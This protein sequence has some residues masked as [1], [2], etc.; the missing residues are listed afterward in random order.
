MGGLGGAVGLCDF[1]VGVG[2][3]F[4]VQAI[5]MHV[6]VM[7]V[8]QQDQVVVVGGSEVATPVV[9]VV[10]VAPGDLAVAAGVAAAAVA[11]CDG[12]EQVA[13]HGAGGPAN[14]WAAR[15]VS[16]TDNGATMA[17]PSDC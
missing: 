14:S 5:A 10:G 9:Y 8:A 16:P 2:E 15:S 17:T 13:W 1:E 4:E 7:P 11:D 3:Q 6:V 12:S